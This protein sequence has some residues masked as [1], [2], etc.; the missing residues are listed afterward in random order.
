[1]AVRPGE[2][3]E[4]ECANRTL[5]AMIAPPTIP[6]TDPIELLLKPGTYPDH[7]Q[8]VHL[9]ET[10]ISWVFLTDWY[11]YKLKKPVHFEFVDFSTPEARRQACEDELVLNRRL[12]PDMYLKVLPITADNRGRLSL[13]GRG[14]AIDWVV[15]MQRLPADRA[16]ERRVPDPGP[17]LI[18][19]HVRQRG[20]AGGSTG[21]YR[22]R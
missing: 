9:I 13:A 18:E 21:P 14:T 8:E 16:L 22:P 10:H 4:I 12:A 20:Q 19:R 1:M 17:G 11:V 3:R 15:K 5:P 7:P 6:V 2:T